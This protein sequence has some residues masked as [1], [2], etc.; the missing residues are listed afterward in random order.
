MFFTACAVNVFISH[1]GHLSFGKNA[2]HEHHSLSYFLSFPL[3]FSPHHLSL[4]L[5]LSLS[6]PAS[7]L[8]HTY[9]DT[10]LLSHVYGYLCLPVAHT[11]HSLRRGDEGGGGG[12]TANNRA[13]R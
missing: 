4:S 1:N 13:Q 5:S 6:I 9:T 2:L 3:S 12:R 8:L 10:H 7:F 11:A